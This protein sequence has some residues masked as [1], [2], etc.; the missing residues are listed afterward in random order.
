VSEPIRLALAGISHETNTFSVVPADLA[1]FADEG[2]LRGD[3]VRDVYASSQADVAGFLAAESAYGVRV[4]P[5]LF[6]YANPSGTITADAFETIVGEIVG[7]VR[8]RGPWDGVLLAQHGAAVS[9]RFRDADA[10]VIRRVREVV[11]PDVPIGMTNDMHA[12]LSPAMIA[13][14]DVTTVY[15]TNPHLD[16]R[17]RGLECAGLVIR[18]IRGEVRPVQALEQIPAAI[19]IVRQYTV[20]SPMR[21]ICEDLDAVLRRPGILTASVAEGYPWADVE[22]MGMSFLAVS[23]GDPSIARDATRWLA[24]RAWERREDFVGREPTADDALRAAD[25]AATPGRGGPVVLMDVGDNIGGGGPGDSTILLEAAQRLGVRGFLCILFDPAAVRMCA[26]A[27]EG[28]EITTTVGAHTDQRHGRPVRVT[29]RVRRLTGGRWEDPE[30]VHGGYRFFDAGPTAVLD[31]TD[32]ATIVLTTRLIAPVSLAQLPAA[33]VDP[34]EPRIIAAKGVVSPRPAYER[35][36]SQI[37]L[38]DTPGVTANDLRGF[39][40]RHRRR[41]LFPLE[42]DLTYP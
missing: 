9:E 30:P 38:V 11:G 2:I 6:T 17:D 37:V 33:G 12:N 25:L 32:G 34:R 41:P 29:G 42:R 1:W 35:V 18:T 13:G 10:E 39:D 40:Y 27:G 36:A 5:L 31:T 21:E 16:A 4:E 22:E 20:V 7:L 14:T 23:D 15:R 24:Q 28:G 3:E 19:E 8:D 26:D